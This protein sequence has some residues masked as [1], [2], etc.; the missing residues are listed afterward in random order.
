MTKGRKRRIGVPRNKN[1]DILSTA[2]RAERR[3]RGDDDWRA[4]EVAHW[5][6]AKMIVQALIKDPRLGTP[7]G[8]MLLLGVPR[9]ITAQM[10]AAG[11]HAFK[12]LN[13]YD[14]IVLGV[15]RNPSGVVIGGV[16]GKS[17]LA[18][19]EDET[20]AG[21]ANGL[22]RLER[23]LG[24]ALMPG[25]S[26]AVKVL[27]RGGEVSDEQADLAILGL[28]ELVKE[29]GFNEISDSHAT[30]AARNY[31]FIGEEK[32]LEPVVIDR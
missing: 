22:M 16:G 13:L 4:R 1:G 7:L 5:Q 21:A 6:R 26:N 2:K 27:L 32:L 23:T 30:K 12:I 14:S 18:D 3:N 24:R 19:P 11:D 20:I 29:Y 10:Y 31:R 25:A 17:V 8:K 28:K 15:N 9:A